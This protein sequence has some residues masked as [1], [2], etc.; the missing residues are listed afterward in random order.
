MTDMRFIKTKLEKKD[1]ERNK[2]LGQKEMILQSLKDL[3]FETPQQA[4]IKVKKITDKLEKLKEK[5]Q[6]GIELFVKKYKD[7]LD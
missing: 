7:L 6:E 5:Q 3:G 4:K 1:Q 2:L